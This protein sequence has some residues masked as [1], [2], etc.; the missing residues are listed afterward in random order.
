MSVA[1]SLSPGG[2]G[3]PAYSTNPP[4]ARP[5]PSAVYRS[6]RLMGRLSSMWAATSIAA[7]TDGVFTTGA[8]P[9][10]SMAFHPKR[11]DE[12]ALRSFRCV[13]GPL[14]SPCDPAPN[15]DCLERHSRPAM[16][17]PHHNERTDHAQ[18]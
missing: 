5:L 11:T 3:S 17:R 10:G 12:I 16:V 6:A 1:F 15:A 18:A 14:R 2:A 7:S 4:P 9:T 13:L 8:A